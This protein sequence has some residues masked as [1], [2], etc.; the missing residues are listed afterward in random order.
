[1]RDQD[2]GQKEE[3]QEETKSTEFI[4]YHTLDISTNILG[5]LEGLF[6]PSPAIRLTYLPAY[7]IRQ[8]T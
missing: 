4:L 3:G 7:E 5:A 6:F 8:G 2:L 1:M